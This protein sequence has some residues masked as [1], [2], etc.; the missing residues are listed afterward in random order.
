MSRAA[1]IS[2]SAFLA[3]ISANTHPD[4]LTLVDT[5]IALARS[6]LDYTGVKKVRY[7]M[8]RPFTEWQIVSGI[9]LLV[10]AE[11]DYYTEISTEGTFAL[12]WSDVSSVS[13]GLP[14]SLIVNN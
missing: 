2:T 14:G 4:D 11:A 1:T 6:E 12:S 3:S 10:A 13:S 8:A 9:D 5:K 7:S